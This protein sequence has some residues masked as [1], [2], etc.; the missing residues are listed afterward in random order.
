[1]SDE[2]AVPIT[3][4]GCQIEKGTWQGDAFHFTDGLRVDPGGSITPASGDS[5]VITL[6]EGSAIRALPEGGFVIEMVEVP[7]AVIPRLSDVPTG[8]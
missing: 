5:A 6:R 2:T 8:S 3:I 7:E 4:A 1:M